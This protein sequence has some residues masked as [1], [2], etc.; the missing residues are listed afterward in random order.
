MALF[1]GIMLACYIALLLFFRTKG[2]YK[3]VELE[4]GDQL[5]ANSES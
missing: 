1:P 4:T 3:P 5:P 2:G